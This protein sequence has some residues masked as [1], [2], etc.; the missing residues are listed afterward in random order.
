MFFWKVSL[1]SL[2]A[3]KDVEGE[4]RQ[5]QALQLCYHFPAKIFS[6]IVALVNLCNG[7]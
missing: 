4:D 6:S 5:H 1:M 7:C 3:V 2:E